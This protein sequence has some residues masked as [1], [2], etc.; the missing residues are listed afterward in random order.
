MCAPHALL[1]KL[2]VFVIHYQTREDVQNAGT[3]AADQNRL[4]FSTLIPAGHL[5]C[6]NTCH[7]RILS[8][9]EPQV[10]DKHTLSS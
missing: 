2:P 5:C 8:Q 7:A 4:S 9:E 6:L 10:S 1:S 3:S